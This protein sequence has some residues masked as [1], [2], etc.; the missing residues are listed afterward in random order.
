MP[1]A[2]P[3]LIISYYRRL[4]Y[5]EIKTVSK[6]TNYFITRFKL[7]HL[8][9]FYQPRTPLR[10]PILS[11][12]EAIVIPIF[13]VISISNIS[14]V[15]RFKFLSI[16]NTFELIRHN[17]NIL[18]YEK[19]MVS[20]HIKDLETRLS[21]TCEFC[22]GYHGGL[23][24]EEQ[25]IV[26]EKEQEVV[27][28]DYNS[29]LQNIL[30]NFLMSNQ[31]SFE[32]FEVQCG[33]LVEKAY[34]S[35][36]K[37]VEMESECQATVVD[38]NAQVINVGFYLK[39]QQMGSEELTHVQMNTYPSLRWENLNSK[40]LTMSAWEYLILYAKFIEFLPNKRKKKDDIFLLSF[41]PP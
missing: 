35:H 11:W 20:L 33:N 40:G 1:K 2:T 30:D 31:V 39:S 37:L 5:V 16:H 22:G 15:F 6:E 24:C 9:I 10:G 27:N 29:Q 17:F 32:K 7:V 13:S 34:E 4:C 26:K 28:I 8:L 38:D 21:I 19:L 41:L 36:Q 23:F 14:I 18:C 12:V 3:N 25:Y